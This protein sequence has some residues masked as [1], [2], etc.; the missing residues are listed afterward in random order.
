MDIYYVY[1]Y[2]RQD[3]TPYYIG[4][5]KGKRIFDKHNV[6]IPKDQSKIIFLETNLSDIGACAL[7]RRYIR[8]YGRKDIGTGI[9]RNMTDGGDGTSGRIFS[10]ETKLK[11]S[12]IHKGSNHSEETKLKI[13][14]SA[15]GKTFSEEHKEKLK[16][17]AKNRKII[18]N[19][20]R[21]KMSEAAKNR[22]RLP[23]STEH[24]QKLSNLLK[25]RKKQPF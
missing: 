4:K 1:A 21:L 3:G 14:R 8:W 24:K 23:L 6:P 22:K 9:L 15:K 20:S 13:S 2:I 11:I 12:K 5:G 10:I 19:E 17:A 18:S 25:G 7:E 16:I